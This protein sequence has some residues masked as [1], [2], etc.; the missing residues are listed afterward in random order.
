M[1]PSA[2]DTHMHIYVSMDRVHVLEQQTMWCFSHIQ[3]HYALFF[4]SLSSFPQEAGRTHIRPSFSSP[5]L[6]L[7][8]SLA[9]ESHY[10]FSNR[11]Y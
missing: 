3:M 7:Y 10:V 4:S 6:T 5:L 1:Q 2:T 11:K 9:R 8:G